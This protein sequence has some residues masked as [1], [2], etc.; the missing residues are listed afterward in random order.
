MPFRRAARR[1]RT[2]RRFSRFGGFRKRRYRRRMPTVIGGRR[3][4]PETHKHDQTV[5]DGTIDIAGTIVH[6]NSI[7]ENSGSL[8]GM[9]GTRCKL[10]YLNWR[11]SLTGSSKDVNE[12]QP[13]VRV[14]LFIDTQGQGGSAP[15]VTDVLQSANVYSSLSLQYPGRFRILHD[16]THA[17]NMTA[18]A[19][20]DA[21]SAIPQ[22]F[23]Q[24]FKRL[25]TTY[26]T[27]SND[28]TAVK[29]GLY[30]LYITSI[31]EEGS[32]NANARVGYFTD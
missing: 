29:N 1:F 2:R 6:L 10:K 19:G 16:K 11:C 28:N 22:H 26:T 12:V 8:I 5:S 31:D 3:S 14:I 32:I 25:N 7:P 17:F 27:N 9:V 30:V 21:G 13:I 23:Y 18:N 24:F 15:A 4:K 20:V